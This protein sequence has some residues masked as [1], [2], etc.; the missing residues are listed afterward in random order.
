[1]C[2]REEFYFFVLDVAEYAMK[3]LVDSDSAY[4]VEGSSV[5]FCADSP[6]L[7]EGRTGSK[8]Q[9]AWCRCLPR[10]VAFQFRELADAFRKQSG[11][12]VRTYEEL[13]LE[14]F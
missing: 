10:W 3:K 13:L 4:F 2:R 7:R 9:V 1:M 6:P 5:S 12:L 11:G 8:Y 14:N